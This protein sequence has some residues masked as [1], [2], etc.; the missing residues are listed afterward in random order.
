MRGL[1]PAGPKGHGLQPRAAHRGQDCRHPRATAA[2][3]SRLPSTEHPQRYTRSPLHHRPSA[4]GQSLGTAY[5]VPWC[6]FDTACALWAVAS[7][8]RYLM[9]QYLDR[10]GSDSMVPSSR[11]GLGMPPAAESNPL[12]IRMIL[13]VS[14]GNPVAGTRGRQVF[15]STAWRTSAEPREPHPGRSGSCARAPRRLASR[16]TVWCSA[17]A[18]HRV[19]TT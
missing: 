7:M 2:R 17:A 6:W 3:G 16:G 19:E 9:G 5:M 8:S 4:G 1:H 13:M 12:R 14:S 11:M 15:L 10:I 18:S